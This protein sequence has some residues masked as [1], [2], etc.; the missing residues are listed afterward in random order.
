M[1]IALIN[2]PILVGVPLVLLL[3]S[4]GLRIAILAF[5]GDAVRYDPFHGHV[6]IGAES[7]LEAAAALADHAHIGEV[8][9]YHHPVTGQSAYSSETLQL[10]PEVVS[11]LDALKISQSSFLGMIGPALVPAI[12]FLMISKVVR[13]LQLVRV[14]GIEKSL[15]HEPP[16]PPPEAI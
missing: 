1:R 12:G 8:L 9:H 3:A 15:F 16:I 13:R 5:P 4:F 6:V 7:H 14:A 10:A 11:L 2:R